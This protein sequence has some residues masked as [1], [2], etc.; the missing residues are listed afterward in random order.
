LTKLPNLRETFILQTDASEC[1]VGA[2]FMQE[3]NDVKMPVAYASRKLN[4]S[5][6]NYA[7]IEKDNG[8]LY[9]QQ[10]V[11]ETDYKPL[12]YLNKTKVANARLMRW[13]LSLQPYGFR[14]VVIKGK[15]NVGVD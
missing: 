7:T 9:G 5:E 2:V 13:T 12:T 1:G 14:I 8:Y 4:K 11:L 3:V 6:T 15:G 10:F